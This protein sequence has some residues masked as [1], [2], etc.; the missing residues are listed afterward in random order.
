MSTAA[1]ILANQ[2]NAQSSTGPASPEG[3][4]ASSKNRTTHGLSHTNTFFYLLPD[5]DGEKFLE[6]NALL[7]EEHQPQTE[8]ERILVRRLGEHEWLRT[9][10]LRLQRCCLSG[11]ANMSILD[12]QQ[13]ALFIRYQT[14]QER[15]FYKA[16]KELQTIRTQREKEQI[17][18]E[19]Q[20]RL[21]AAEQRAAEAHNLKKQEFELKKGEFELKKERLASPKQPEKSEKDPFASASSQ[22]STAPTPE[23]S[24]G[25]LEMAA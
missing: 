17:G 21:Q 3:K 25:D 14:T 18:F 15:A 13:F 7:R 16:L 22:N 6:L 19:S 8:T 9:R 1:Q 20:K 11:P 24:P 10:A 2:K 5:E 23:P 4:R 12:N